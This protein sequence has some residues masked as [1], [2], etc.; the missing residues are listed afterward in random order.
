MSDALREIIKALPRHDW[1]SDVGYDESDEG[2]YVRIDDVLAAFP[3]EKQRQDGLVPL[4]LFV[5]TGDDHDY[6]AMSQWL[7]GVFL[8]KKDA[9]EAGEADEAQVVAAAKAQGA[10]PLRT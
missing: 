9:Q 3:A 8:S 10:T 4:D 1:W 6:D 2:P 5:C 7:I